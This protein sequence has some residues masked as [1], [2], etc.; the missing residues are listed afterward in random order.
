MNK[1][2]NINRNIFDVLIKEKMTSTISIQCRYYMCGKR[3]DDN[4]SSS[5]SLG[6][7]GGNSWNH[8]KSHNAKKIF[9]YKVYIYIYI[10]IYKDK[11][12]FD[13]KEREEEF[14]GIRRI[15]MIKKKKK[16]K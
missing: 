2:M 14:K 5:I 6:L 10:Y 16:I 8:Q 13:K 12:V 7:Q 1:K 9:G 11:E 3:F 15:S 4:D